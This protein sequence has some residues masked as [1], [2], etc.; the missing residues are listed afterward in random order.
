MT[1]DNWKAH[2][3]ADDQWQEWP[4]ADTGPICEMCGQDEATLKLAEAGVCDD[5]FAQEAR[6]AMR[7]LLGRDC[8]C[9]PLRYNGVL[10]VCLNP[11]GVEHSHE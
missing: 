9:D 7:I 4:D 8:C 2:N 6:K 1:Y 5:C 11:C 3:P 10:A